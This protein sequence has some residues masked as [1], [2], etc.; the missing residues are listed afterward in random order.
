[1]RLVRTQAHTEKLGEELSYKSS[2][3]VRSEEKK[4]NKAENCTEIEQVDRAAHQV[5]R[6]SEPSRPTY[7]IKSVDFTTLRLKISRLLLC[8]LWFVLLRGGLVIFGDYLFG[9]VTFELL[10]L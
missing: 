8:P 6:P 7:S 1:M 2:T 10:L 5:D 3:G 9:H 4:W